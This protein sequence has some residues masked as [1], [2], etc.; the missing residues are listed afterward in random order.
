M[1]PSNPHPSPSPAVQAIHGRPRKPPRRSR[2]SRLVAIALLFLF[3]PIFVFGA[4]VAA[5]GTVTVRVAEHGPDGVNLWIPVPALLVDVAVMAVPLVMPDDALADARRELAPYRHQ[6][7]A[8]AEAL[9]EVPSGS[10]LVDV[11]DGNEHVRITKDWRNFE[12]TVESPDTDVQV[13]VPARLLSRSL[14]IFG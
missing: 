6:I 13:S 9:E 10:V 7:R 3:M 2:L 4:T 11:R 14:D 1:K 8:L 5:T 12:V